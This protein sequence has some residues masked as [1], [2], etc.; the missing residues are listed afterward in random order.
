MKAEETKPLITHV[1]RQ[2]LPNR[3]GLEDVVANLCHELQNRNYRVRVV[4]LDRLFSRPDEKLSPHEVINGVE[5]IRIPWR[6]SKRYPFAPSVFHHLSDADIIHVH[7]IDFFY[8][9]LAWGWLLHRKPL[10]VTTHGGFFHTD[11]HSRLKTVW[12]NTITR[13]SALAYR[14]IIGCSKADVRLFNR[15]AASRTM[16]IENAAGVDKFRDA[17]SHTALPR[18]IT[19][20]RFSAN[21]QLGNLLEAVRVLKQENA[22]WHLDICGVPSDLTEA[23]LRGR[24]KSLGIEANVDLHIGISNDEIKSIMGKTSLFVSASDYEGFGLVAVEAMSAGL[25]PVLQP[26]DAYRDLAGTHAFI[27]LA[28]FFRPNDAAA[29]IKEALEAVQKN[30]Q[31][32]REQTMEAAQGY[33]WQN[34]AGQYAAI[35]DDI[36]Q[37]GKNG[38][39]QP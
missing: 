11:A 20:G 19:I 6:G 14:K 29:A 1:V 24:I 17:A 13:L 12:L 10:V 39:A 23:D 32:I 9:A 3:G 4:T 5:V 18:M 33:S 30:P 35:Y 27:R 2:F 36:L 21:K 28:D 8:D 25:L 15:I 37:A 31:T 34:A 26:N 38:G 7:A 16:L 22:E